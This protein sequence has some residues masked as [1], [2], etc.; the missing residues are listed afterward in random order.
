MTCDGSLVFWTDEPGGRRRLGRGGSRSA[1]PDGPAQGAFAGCPLRFDGCADSQI[2]AL[3]TQVEEGHVGVYWRGGALLSSI[4]RP[5]Y[6]WYGCTHCLVSCFSILI[7]LDPSVAICRKSPIDSFRGVQ[8]TMQVRRAQMERRLRVLIIL[9]GL[10]LCADG[11]GARHPVWYQ[12]R[13]G[14][15]L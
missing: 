2:D 15:V 3:T 1:A 10:R 13:R 12:W 6:H 8:V 9:W 5:G 7:K 11:S 4:T 14:S